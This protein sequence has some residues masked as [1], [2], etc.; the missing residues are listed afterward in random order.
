MNR[1]FATACVLA[2]GVQL[3][4]PGAVAGIHQQAVQFAKG[5]SSAQLQGSIEGD[6]ETAYTVSA[7]AGQTLAVGMKSSNGSLNFNILPPGSK[8]AMFVGSVQGAQASVVLPADGTYVVQVYLMRNAARRHEGASYSLTIGVTRQALAPLT[9]AQDALIAGTP[10]HASAAVPCQ[11]PGAKAGGSCQAFVTRRG[12]DGT[13]TVEVHGA[14]DLVR[15][16]LFVK[17]KP[18]ASDSAQALTS[19]RQGD[20]VTVRIGADERFDVPDV[21]LSGG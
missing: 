8:L 11:P 12:R 20:W 10:F 5:A 17:G 14:N 4:L 2:I 16:V 13:A 9:G 3:P 15:R 7:R 21:F 19:S 1:Q 18:V 6:G